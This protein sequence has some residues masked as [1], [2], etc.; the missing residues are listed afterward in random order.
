MK[1]TNYTIEIAPF[2][3]AGNG[4]PQKTAAQTYPDRPGPVGPLVFSDI[5][6]DS[7]NVSWTPPT[8][9]NGQILGYVVT[10]KTYKLEQ[11][12]KILF[13]NGS[14]WFFRFLS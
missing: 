2:N 5:Q 8:D 4:P 9:R 13:W 7:V 3:R 10:Y 12:E 11:G 14:F 1:F 6:L